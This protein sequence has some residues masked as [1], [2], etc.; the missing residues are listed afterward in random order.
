[1]S[2]DP[3]EIPEAAQRDDDPLA[4]QGRFGGFAPLAQLGRLL[5]TVLQDL[6]TIAES[7]RV[8]PRA[9]EELAAIRSHVEVL[10]DEV[11]RMRRGVDTVNEGV[12]ELR[13]T[14][15]SE[16]EDIDL[17]VHPLRRTRR[18]L[19]RREQAPELDDEQAPEL[20]GDA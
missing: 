20:G 14:V 6:R 16:L 18:K 1:M 7:V 2:A 12:V 11:H 5:P 4:D 15:S 13:E 10:N 19:S 8:L 9:I 3:T 17:A